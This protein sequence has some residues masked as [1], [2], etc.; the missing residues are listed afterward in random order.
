MA[1]TVNWLHL[2]DLHFGLDDRGWLWPRVKH[3]FF[4]DVERTVATLGGCD[5]VFFTG[6]LTQRG[7][8]TEFEKLNKEIEALWGVLS[9]GGRAPQLCVIPGNHDLVRPPSGSAIAKTLTQLWWQDGDLRRKFWAE[10]DSEYRKGMESFFEHYSAWASKLPVPTIPKTPGA[11]PGDFSAT[12]EKGSIRLGVIGLNSTF[13]QIGE[14]E[15]KGKLDLHISQ[16]NAACGSD[17][18]HWLR[19][20]TATVLLTHQPPS[21]LGLEALQHFRQEIYPPG[22]FL[23]QLCGHQHEPEAFELSEAGAAPRRLRQAPSLFG[24]EDWVG[25]EPVKRTHGYTAGQYVFDGQG[26]YER[27]LPR[28]AVAGRHGGLNLAPDH[29]YKLDNEESVI[30]QFDLDADEDGRGPGAH[31]KLLGGEGA[32]TPPTSGS[33]KPEVQLLK[34]P[35]DE[36]TSKGRLTVCPRLSLNFGPQHRFIRQEEQSQFEHELRKSRCVWLVADWGTAK[37]RFVGSCIDRFRTTDPTP[38][39]FHLRCDDAADVDALEALFP[40]QFGMPLQTFCALV[41]SLSGCFLVLDALHPELCKEGNLHRIKQIAN[42]VTDYCQNLRLI[43]ISRLPPE[44]DV[45][46]LVQLRSLEVPD[47]R[48]Y[49]KYHPDAAAGLCEPDVVEELHE[50]SD[51]LPMHLDRMLRALKV[52]SLASVLE[53]ERGGVAAPQGLPETTP[54]AI[55]HAIS[56][57]ASSLDKRS[58]RSFRLLKVLS[59]LP[60]GEILEALGHYLPT[61][62]FFSENALQLHESALLDVIPLQQT[63]PQVGSGRIASTEQTVP[64]LLKAPREV[65][66]HVQTL[67]SDE[68]RREI[69]FAGAERFFGRG[70]RKGKFKLRSLPPEYRE[71]LSSGAGNEFAL[72]H[73]LIAHGKARADDALV[74][75]GQ[76]L[77]VQYARHLHSAERFRD[78]AVVAVALLQSVE[79][80]NSPEDWSRLA[81][82]AGAGLRMTGKREE[83]L[84]YLKW[85]LEVGAPSLGGEEKGEIWLDVSLAEER[86]GHSDEAVAAAEKVKQYCGEKSTRRLQALATIAGLTLGEPEK[87]IE[88]AALEKHSREDGYQALADTIALNLAEDA[89]TASEKIRYLDKVLAAETRGYNQVRAV[90]SK[91]EA[92]EK[93]ERPGKLKPRELVTLAVAYSYLHA[94]RFGSLFDRCHKALWRMLEEE[95]DTSQ[96]LRLFRHSSFVWRIRGDEAKESEY[97]TRLS[98]RNVQ[99]AQPSGPKAF[100][101]E[102][103]YFLRRLKTITLGTAGGSQEKTDA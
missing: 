5:L 31:S 78:L 94:Q 55:V 88:L 36:N 100:I 85:S 16:I 66:D 41:G 4:R 63:T 37:E 64:K 50:Q 98:S 14:G 28:I 86:L 83:A 65:R 11:L 19:E 97:L 8:K 25:P 48:T 95:G 70:W 15:F 44:V 60:Y 12:F 93:L 80:D 27:L 58:R 24:L 68:E 51:G 59:V 99:A 40:Q 20:R 42:A 87:S 2:S 46:Q 102:V 67:L 69:V 76:W 13:L 74:R 45:F 43:F 7:E 101:I 82:L 29:S 52:S 9:K 21:W 49:L 1:E 22:R 26:G 92:V 35:P 90:V 6:D 23:A 38:D 81:A 34:S 79:R 89:K 47:V 77:A 72:I 73:H 61:E 17:P 30:T 33:L 56:A 84:K 54:K 96:L 18:V 75:R 57:L 53:A 62:P 71:Y 10:R 91:A 39:V 3:D 103:S 32:A